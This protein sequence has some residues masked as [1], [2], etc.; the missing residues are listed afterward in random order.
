M[1]ENKQKSKISQHWCPNLGAGVIVMTSG[2]ENPKT[3]CLSSHLCGS[4]GEKCEK[5]SM[6]AESVAPD[7]K[8]T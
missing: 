3:T 2:G 5:Q 6:P 1:S 4:D 8:V 7:S